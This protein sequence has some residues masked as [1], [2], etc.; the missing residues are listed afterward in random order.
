M[1]A[2]QQDMRH[3]HPLVAYCS[4]RRRPIPREQPVMSTLRAAIFSGRA[5]RGVCL[6]GSESERARRGREPGRNLEDSALSGC[7]SW[8]GKLES[9]GASPCVPRKI[10]LR[11]GARGM[12]VRVRVGPCPRKRCV[13][14]HNDTAWRCAALTRKS[15]RSLV[16]QRLR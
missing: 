8:K 14:E 16:A 10:K 1:R 2:N 9:W 5:W 3:T 4:T 7:V 6:L 11:G 12:E 13:R 15:A